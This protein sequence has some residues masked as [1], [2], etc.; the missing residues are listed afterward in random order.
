MKNF[1]LNL[2]KNEFF[3]KIFVNNNFENK[4]FASTQIIIPR[5]KIDIIKT[6]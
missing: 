6:F 2:S 3:F 1:E 4:L 5:I